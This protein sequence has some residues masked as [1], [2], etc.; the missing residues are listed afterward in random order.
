MCSWR[1]TPMKVTAKQLL[2]AADCGVKVKKKVT[3]KKKFRG[4]VLKQKKPAGT[5]AAP[6]TVVPIV[7]GQK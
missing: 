1:N 5:T 7:I 3:H 6:G 2:A 4:K